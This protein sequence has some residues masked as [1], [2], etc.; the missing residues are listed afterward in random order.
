MKWKEDYRDDEITGLVAE[1]KYHLGKVL[2]EGELD[3]DRAV[4]ELEEALRLDP[5]DIRAHYFLGRAIREQ[6]ERNRFRRAKEVLRR[7]LLEGAP[8]GHEDE[9]RLFLGSRK[10]GSTVNPF[11]VTRPPGLPP[12]LPRR[13]P[14]GS[15]D[16]IN[17]GPT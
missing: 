13:H 9:V 12:P 1:A 8:L 11:P 3:F 15:L 10:Q 16:D 6:V 7:Y 5:G 14:M 17:G 4:S 2:C